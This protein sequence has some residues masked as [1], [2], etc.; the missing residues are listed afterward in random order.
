MK[1]CCLE[2]LL[3]GKRSIEVFNTT[4]T[5]VLYDACKD[6]IEH[7]SVIDEI[8][9][10]FMRSHAEPPWTEGEHS[11]SGSNGVCVRFVE[12]AVIFALEAKEA[13]EQ[14]YDPQ[15]KQ[16][17]NTGY[18]PAN[19]GDHNLNMREYTCGRIYYWKRMTAHVIA[20]IGMI[21]RASRIACNG[22][23]W[24]R[25]CTTSESW[26]SN[27]FFCSFWFINNVNILKPNSGRNTW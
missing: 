21:L 4:F 27:Y 2:G 16:I 20:A 9:D 14:E 10:V 26:Y 19:S 24:G 25:S 1:Q 11:G 18:I 5:M 22:L 15:T 17:N 8:D 6:R 13:K 12:V 7:V 23:K 3:E